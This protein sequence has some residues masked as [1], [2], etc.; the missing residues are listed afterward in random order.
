MELPVLRKK[1]RDQ[2]QD[3]ARKDPGVRRPVFFQAIQALG[4]PSALLI[5]GVRRVGKTTLMR[6]MYD[7]LARERN[8]PDE[9][10]YFFSF[11]EHQTRTLPFLT[12]LLETWLPTHPRVGTFV[13]L[14]ELQYID[15]WQGTLKR[16]LDFFPNVKF[17]LS[18]SA[19]L[20]MKQKSNES[21]AGRTWEITMTPLSFAEFQAIFLGTT[22]EEFDLKH[23]LV[24]PDQKQ[25]DGLSDQWD[26]DPGRWLTDFASFQ[27]TGQFPEAK[28]YPTLE[29]QYKYINEGI[30]QKLIQIDLPTIFPTEHISQFTQLFQVVIQETGNYLSLGNLA[31][32][33]GI[34][35]NTLK[36]YLD[37][38][39]QAFLMERAITFKKSLR[40][41]SR[42]MQKLYVVSA[43]FYAARNHLS[44]VFG[45]ASILGHLLETTVFWKLDTI[46]PYVFFYHYQQQEVDFLATDD[47]LL[48]QTIPVEVKYKTVIT[49]ADVKHLLAYMERKKITNGFVIGLTAEK[50][51]IAGKTI[52]ILPAPLVL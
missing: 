36:R 16:Y 27:R 32:E 22:V 50:R 40:K 15:H 48:K 41:R 24:Q 47:P 42:A 13:F 21:L 12:Q 31:T 2:K 1:I 52:W 43:N 44:E 5:T 6:Q 23:F 33:L 28:A 14:D 35:Q 51:I 9:R 20:F 45:D 17:I 7:Y 18:G 8:I 39:Y 25:F 11:D 38:F 29:E 10:I 34:A 37:I 49:P 4:L 26:S 30:Y 19:S 46:F 3:F